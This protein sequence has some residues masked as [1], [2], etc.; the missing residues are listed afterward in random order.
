MV[1]AAIPLWVVVLSQIL[2]IGQVAATPPGQPAVTAHPISCEQPTNSIAEP[3]PK[4]ET[5]VISQANRSMAEQEAIYQMETWWRERS[6]QPDAMAIEPISAATQGAIS[7][8]ETWWRER[9]KQPDAMAIEPISPATQGAIS[10]DPTDL[11]LAQVGGFGSPGGQSITPPPVTTGRE[12]AA[13]SPEAE[14]AGLP[15]GNWLVL[16]SASVA[17]FYDTNPQQLATGQKPGGGLR[18]TPSFLAQQ[19]SGVYSTTLYGLVDGLIYIPEQVANANTITAKTGVTEIYQP[20]QDWILNGQLDYTR[21]KD[22]FATFAVAPSL[23]PLNPTGVGLSPTTNPLSYNQFTAAG[24]VQ[25]N[26]SDG[27]VIGN[28]SVVGIVYS[29][30]SASAPSPNGVF[31]TGSLRGGYWVLPDFYTFLGG[32]GNSYQYAT[33]N[34][35]SNGYSIF[36]GVGSDQIGLF[37]GEAYAGFQSEMYNSTAGTVNSPD[38]GGRLHYYP[39]PEFTADFFFDRAFGASLLASASATQPGAPTLVTTVLGQGSYKLA[40]EWGA[41]GRAGYINTNYIDT[42]RR[43]NAWTVGATISYSVWQNLGLA[44]DYQ[45]I[46][47]N[48]NVPLQSFTRSVVTL[49]L[50]YKY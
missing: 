6:K 34:L 28:G 31:F 26:A 32:S 22:L 11:Q 7:Q 2:V 25:K 41:S 10:R 20:S 8:M 38:F 4:S 33:S 1:R 17:G 46:N 49:G 35:S 16:P 50:T 27:F 12:E 36:A 42:I 24:S 43:D 18:L 45:Y 29:G 47:L 21:Q 39:V 37:K 15:L 48:S 3:P 13:P 30:T 9:N 5:N 44:L 14:R 23:V 19:T 40:P